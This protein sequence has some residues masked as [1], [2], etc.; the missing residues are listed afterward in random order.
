M[1][2]ALRVGLGMLVLGVACRPGANAVPSVGATPSAATPSAVM[3]PSGV[4]PVASI[5]GAASAAPADAAPAVREIGPYELPFLGTRNVYFVV[6]SSTE[7]P[8]RLVA[9]L[10]GLC[11]PP[12]YACGYWTHAA[13]QVGFL[14]CPSGNSTCGG[15]S[16]PPT[17]TEPYGKIDDD[18]E[19]AIRKIEETYPGEVSR[20][21]AVL[22]GFSLGA[23]AA[24]IVAARHPGRW[25]YLIL[26]EANVDLT[27]AGLRQAG[28]AAVALIAGERGSQLAGERKTCDALKKQGYPAELWVMPKAGHYY[29][30]NID[31]IMRDALAFVL[32]H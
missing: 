27:A 7:G 10:H 21:G 15:A 22:T 13:S 28:V 20:E 18:L 19:A 4:A 26:N 17:W 8:Q 24:P 6:P 5:T 16:G 23:Y 9:N 14:V 31:D 2:A 32:A 3:A 30:A 12:G 11:N 29:S 25:K 1:R